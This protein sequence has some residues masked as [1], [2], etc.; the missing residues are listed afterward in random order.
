MTSIFCIVSKPNVYELRFDSCEGKRYLNSYY[1]NTKESFV[2]DP[3]FCSTIKPTM[4]LLYLHIW[5]SEQQYL[6]IPGDKISQIWEG[7]TAYIN[8]IPLMEGVA[9]VGTLDINLVSFV[10]I[11]SGS[12][13][14]Y[15]VLRQNAAENAMAWIKTSYLQH[16]RYSTSL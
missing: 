2:Q 10:H 11:S 1:F 12:L 14:R 16:L 5:G 7:H 6:W 3:C 15:N 9:V 13:E 4:K 8:D